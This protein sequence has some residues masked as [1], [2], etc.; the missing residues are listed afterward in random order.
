MILCFGQQNYKGMGEATM[1]EKNKISHRGK[2]LKTCC[3]LGEN[4]VKIGITGD[5]HGSKQ[6]IRQ[7]LHAVPPVEYWFHTGDYSQDGRFSCRNQAAVTGS[8]RQY[9]SRRR[10]SK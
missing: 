7:V 3:E 10:E 1:Q 6:A 5:T 8:M 9:R 2:L 4:E